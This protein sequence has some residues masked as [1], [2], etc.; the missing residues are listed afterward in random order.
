MKPAPP[1][2]APPLAA[3]P[4]KGVA[5]AIALTDEERIED[6]KY[7]PRALRPRVFEEERFVFPE[8]YGQTRIR[9]HVKDPEWIFVNWDVDAK[10][11][12][13]LRREVGERVAALTRLTLRVSDAEN[14]GGQTILLPPGARTWYVRTDASGARAYRAELGVTLPSGDFRALA[15]SNTIVP[16]RVGPSPESVKVRRRFAR[17]P[18]AEASGAPETLAAP[19]PTAGASSSPWQPTPLRSDAGHELGERASQPAGVGS[20]SRSAKGRPGRSQGGASE[21]LAGRERGG[22]SDVHRR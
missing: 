5:P 14:G 13:A 11:L 10:T 19:V 22:A 1:K 8:S 17:R 18:E 2:A 12:A 4:V 16:P 7:Q 3:R 15:T 9:L 20:E 6:A 21:L